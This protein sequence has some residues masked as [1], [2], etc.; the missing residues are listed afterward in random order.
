MGCFVLFVC[1]WVWVLNL[2]YLNALFVLKSILVNYIF[3]EN[4]SF[5]QN[6]TCRVMP[7]SFLI[8]KFFFSIFFF[9]SWYVLLHYGFLR[10][11]PWVFDPLF[12]LQQP[13]SILIC[14]AACV[15][16]TLFFCLCCFLIFLTIYFS[17]WLCFCRGINLLSLFCLYECDV[18]VNS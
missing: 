10:L 8:S 5:N 12:I 15:P 11:L 16:F 18:G 1:V 4:Y 3:S 9:D 17:L 14:S 6:S 2:E 13:V 7:E